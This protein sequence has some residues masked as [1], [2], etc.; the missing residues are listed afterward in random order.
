[1]TGNPVRTG[2]GLPAPVRHWNFDDGMKPHLDTVK[3]S[4]TDCACSITGLMTLFKKGVSGTALALDGYYAG[5]SS[6]KARAIEDALSVEAWVAL[7]A[8]P[9]NTA[10]LIHHSRVRQR[11]LVSRPRCLRPSADKGG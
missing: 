6:D 2:K 3:E 11:R 8:Y 7:D 1:M 10:P 5:V 4:I 9:Y